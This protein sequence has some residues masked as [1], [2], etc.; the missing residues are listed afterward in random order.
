M[1]KPAISRK[2]DPIDR[3]PDH[4]CNDDEWQRKVNPI[5]P[6]NIGHPCHDEQWLELARALGR[7]EAEEEYELLHCDNKGLSDG[8]S[9]TKARY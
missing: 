1:P 5:D 8:T 9:K 4:P 2:P 6:R 3:H 7:M